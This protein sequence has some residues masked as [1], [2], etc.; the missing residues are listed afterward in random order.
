M[1]R[2]LV[3]LDGTAWSGAILPDALRLGGPDGVIILLNVVNLV[4]Y[5]DEA[6]AREERAEVESSRAYLTEVAVGLRAGPVRVETQT[7]V[8]DRDNVPR[9]IDEAAMTFDADMVAMATHARA[10]PGDPP[11]ES[12][13]WQALARSPVPVLIRHVPDGT[14]AP[15]A[16]EPRER[17][18]MV[19]LDGSAL[20]EKAL[21]LARQLAAEWNASLWLV[22][23]VSHR[24]VTDFAYTETDPDAITD[25]VASRSAQRYLDRLASQLGRAVE[26]RVLVGSP[27]DE[28]VA[29]AAALSISDVALSSHGR[30]GLAHAVTGSVAD[31][32]LHRLDLPMLVVPAGAT[33]SS[34]RDGTGRRKEH[35]H[36]HR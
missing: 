19:P 28:L 9:T 26:T 10:E 8:A 35:V 5:R 20:A 13:A 14:S 24:P 27:T 15:A 2:V 22:H 33:D 3:P 12:I 6:F 31:G 18:I 1:R 34:N 23:V 16:P 32:V 17:R 4:P 29:A 21:P 25:D 36:D 30:T 7:M 11:R